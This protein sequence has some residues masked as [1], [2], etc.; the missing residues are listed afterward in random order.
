MYGV[1][2]TSLIGSVKPRSEAQMSVRR[3]SSFQSV[4][5]PGRV[6]IWMCGRCQEVSSDW[7]ASAAL[8]PTPTHLPVSRH[9]LDMEVLPR[10]QLHGHFYSSLDQITADL[11]QQF[12][13]NQFIMMFP[14]R[15]PI[16]FVVFLQQTWVSVGKAIQVL[17]VFCNS[18]NFLPFP[19][20]EAP[21]IFLYSR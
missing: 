2:L 12:Y 16:I 17:A 1:L 15:Q 9:R 3:I 14:Y 4:L 20:P 19:N 5:K 18:R 7:R 8:A 10:P 11:D 13:F 6:H 21:S